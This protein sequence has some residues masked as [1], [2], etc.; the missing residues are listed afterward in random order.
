VLVL[1]D[2]PSR[3]G[4]TAEGRSKKLSKLVIMETLD[5]SGWRFSFLDSI[6]E[7]FPPP[8]ASALSPDFLI[9]ADEVRWCGL[10]AILIQPEQ[11]LG[12]RLVS[13]LVI[14]M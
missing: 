11:T 1:S 9:A 12:W 4:R 3:L 2:P 14:Y 13:A 6:L 7:R 10:R 8:V 5:S